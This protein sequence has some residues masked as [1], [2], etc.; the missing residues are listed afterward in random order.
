LSEDTSQTIWLTSADGVS[1]PVNEQQTFNRMRTS[2]RTLNVQTVLRD[3]KGNTW[4]G[5]LGQGLTR[6]SNASRNAEE[7]ERFSQSDGLSADSVWC[8]L[9]DREHNIWVGTQNGLNR[10]RDEKVT[11]LTRREGLIRDDVR[12][13]A[14]GPDGS[15]WASTSVGIHRI[16]GEHRELY[17]EGTSILGLHVDRHNT[18][19][20]GTNHGIGRMERGRWAYLPVPTGI[21]LTAVT[22]ITGDGK[23]GVWLVDDRR[24]LYR[25]T[26]GRMM[27]F[28]DEPLLKGK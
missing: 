26:N 25:W 2:S 13:L 21:Q 10:F 24:G 9:E 22:A 18:L 4:I 28:S 20:A 11:T 12:A 27:D 17:L 3:G 19:W 7:I 5:T 15:I 14:A 16:D 23:E 8:L 6:L 1:Q